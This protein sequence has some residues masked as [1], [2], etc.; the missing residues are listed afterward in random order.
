MDVTKAQ[1]VLFPFYSQ[2]DMIAAGGTDM[3]RCIGVMDEAFALL[4]KGDYVMGRPNRNSHGMRLWFPLEPQHP[5][6]P[7]GGPDQRFLTL[8]AYLGGR[9][10]ACGNKWY[11]SN[12]HNPSKHGLPRSILLMI[13]NEAETARPLAI[14]EANLLSGMRTGAV[15]GLSA[16]Y[17]ARKDSQRLGVIAA[18]PIS[19]FC[20]RAIAAELPSLTRVSVYDIV[21]EK[22][23]AFAEQMS[24]E[25]G[26]EVVPVGSLPEAVKGQDVVS[27]SSSGSGG[28]LIEDNWLK[29]G[30]L[31]TLSSRVRFEDSYLKSGRIVADIWKMHQAYRDEGN[32]F[33][34]A[35][36]DIIGR[37]AGQIFKSNWIRP[38]DMRRYEGITSFFKIVGRD[39]MPSKVLRCTEAYLD[40]SY[41]GNLFDLLCSSIGYYGIEFRAHIDN[42]ALGRTNFL[43]M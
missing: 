40:E 12:I 39:M 34:F 1:P 7:N 31:L 25:L 8:P 16:R 42:K 30:S 15:I 19:K 33:S 11:G 2:L 38:E 27:A 5:G 6:M 14:M 22:G 37:D 10:H 43:I 36:G 18:G 13:L 9:F 17:L 35:C 24:A 20:T 26:I 29:E 21:P 4:G 41:D 23:A 28:P 32:A 3:K